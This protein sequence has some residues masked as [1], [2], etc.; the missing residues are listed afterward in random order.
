MSFQEFTH[1]MRILI[2][3]QS[4]NDQKSVDNQDWPWPLKP[5]GQIALGI[6]TSIHILSI[7]QVCFIYLLELQ[8]TELHGNNKEW[9]KKAS[10]T[11]GDID[12]WSRNVIIW[13]YSFGYFDDKIDKW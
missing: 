5:Q 4:E 9:K 7:Y 10:M 6:F 12:I 11:F 13:K 1:N 8:I 3:I 2:V